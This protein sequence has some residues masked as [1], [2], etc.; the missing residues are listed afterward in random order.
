MRAVLSAAELEQRLAAKG[1]LRAYLL[2]KPDNADVIDFY[3]RLGWERMP[4][5]IMA[6]HL[7]SPTNDDDSRP[8]PLYEPG[9]DDGSTTTAVP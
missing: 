8:N 7:V 6:K 1:C 5:A 3:D 2:V 9:V 4:H